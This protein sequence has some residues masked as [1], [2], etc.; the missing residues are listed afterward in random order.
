MVR[1]V[2]TSTEDVD[3]FLAT[4]SECRAE[5]FHRL[6]QIWFT[7]LRRDWEDKAKGTA[8]KEMGVELTFG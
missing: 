2:R 8:L 4:L 3:S 5:R 1:D 6:R 7:E